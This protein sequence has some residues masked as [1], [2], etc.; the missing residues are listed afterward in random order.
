MRHLNPLP[1]TLP[2]RPAP[3]TLMA[4][5]QFLKGAAMILIA[6]PPLLGHE[7]SLAYIP[8]LRDIIF[9]AS[10][11]RDPHGL[12]LLLLGIY[13]TMI[14][15]GLWMLKRWA[16]NSL[17]GTSG[18]MLVLWLAHNNFGTP[19][20]SMPAISEVESQTV[21][22]LLLIDF[23]VFLYLKFHTETYLAFPKQKGR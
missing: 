14:G 9:L 5:L 15:R 10:H 4:L 17:M 13:A 21:Y 8:D 3:V 2:G 12:L 16:R 20:F 22:I 7:G 19:I 18:V 1:P 11:G 23:A 6:L